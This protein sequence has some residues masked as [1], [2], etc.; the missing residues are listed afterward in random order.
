[1]KVLLNI[2]NLVTRVDEGTKRLKDLRAVLDKKTRAQYK[3]L[4][5]AECFDLLL[6]RKWYRSLVNGI[7]ALYTAVNHRI[8][9][10]VTELADRY[11]KPLPA[12]EIEVAEHEGKVKS[13]LEK[14][15][16]VW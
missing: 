2:S 14:M 13:H 15:G 16:F 12:L 10:R 1:V 6:E 9:E 3:K 7:F 4:T 5:D 11:E 8:T